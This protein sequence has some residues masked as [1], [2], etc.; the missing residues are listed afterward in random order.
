[1]HMYLSFALAF[2]CDDNVRDGFGRVDKRLL[3]KSDRPTRTLFKAGILPLD[4]DSWMT[5]AV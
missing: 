2:T 4:F 5:F 3:N 1:M